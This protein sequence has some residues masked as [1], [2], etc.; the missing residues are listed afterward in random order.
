MRASDIRGPACHCGRSRPK[1]TQHIARYTRC[2]KSL[3]QK[4]F[5]CHPERREGS[6]SSAITGFSATLRMTIVVKGEFCKR[7][8]GPAFFTVAGLGYSGGRMVFGGSPPAGSKTGPA[9][10]KIYNATC[11]ASHPN[12]GNAMMANLPIPVPKRW[13]ISRHLMTLYVSPCCPAGLK[14]PCRIFLIKRF[15]IEKSRPCMTMSGRSLGTPAHPG[16]DDSFNA[17]GRNLHG[18]TGN[19]A[20]ARSHQ[21][22]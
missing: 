7:L 10:E 15:P 18:W 13:Q 20:A 17:W 22:F 4:S 19:T 14:A 21:L 3:L 5:F 6:Q 2:Q 8:C 11:R 9:G 12:G 16:S 1:N